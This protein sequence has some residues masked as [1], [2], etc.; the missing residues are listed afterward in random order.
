[1]AKIKALDLNPKLRNQ[2][3]QTQSLSPK[4]PKPPKKSEIHFADR[5]FYYGLKITSWGII[6]L[7][8]SMVVLI[9]KMSWPALH[10]FGF[11]FFFNTEWNSV[12]QE[13]GALALIHGTLFTSL[14]A[15]ILAVPVGVGVALFLNEI[16]PRRLAHALSFLIE[17]LA[18]IP[19]VVYGFWGLFVLVPWLRQSL[20]PW[21]V[22]HFSW[23]PLFKGYPLGVGIMAASIVLA[24][25]IVP[26]IA[27]TCREVFRAI[28]Q[29]HREAALAL[30]ATRWEMICLA[31]LKAGMSGVIG[32]IILGLGRALGETMAVTMVIGNRIE[33]N[34]SLLAPAQTMASV[35]ANQYAEADSDLHLSALTGV[36]L[37]LF[38]VSILVNGGARFVVWRIE[39]KF[40]GAK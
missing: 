11:R 31:V 1:M 8:L 37:T 18:A 17:T 3:D 26:T 23:M 25:M 40:R 14:G 9:F 32:G 12:T 4:K 29:S 36:G 22:D 5:A 33:L 35:L 34:W 39:R 15:L 10:H 20:Q 2:R 24:I 21:L 27:S 28:P 6:F 7:L 19:S 16:A 38:A 30:G 13:F